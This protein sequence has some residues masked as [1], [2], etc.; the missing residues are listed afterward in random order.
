MS[1]INDHGI[2]LFCIVKI[3]TFAKKVK[4]PLSAKG[5]AQVTVMTKTYLNLHGTKALFKAF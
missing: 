3:S 5:F 4:T 2:T 1:T